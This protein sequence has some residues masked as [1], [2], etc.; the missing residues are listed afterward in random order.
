MAKVFVYP[1]CNDRVAHLGGVRR[2]LQQVAQKHAAIARGVLLAHRAEGHARITVTRGDKL[3]YFVNLVDK[4]SESN[5]YKP[6][7][8]AIEFGNKYGGGGI[9]ALGRAFGLT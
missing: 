2:E 5:D 8:A 7:A 4:P 3:D 1:E 6:A 9:D